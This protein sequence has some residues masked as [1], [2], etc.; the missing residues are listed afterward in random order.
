LQFL[1][2]LQ[3]DNRQMSR[4]AIIPLGSWPRRMPAELAAGYC[5][6][7]TVEAFIA[8]VG[9]DYPQPRV[10]EGRRRLWLKDDLDKAIMPPDL[11]D[12]DAAEDL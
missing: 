12:R 1:H 9:N 8:R 3:G 4:P 11:S 2:F 6:E 10:S 7:R 5:G